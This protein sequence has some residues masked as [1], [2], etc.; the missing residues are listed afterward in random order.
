MLCTSCCFP[1]LLA[2]K[3]CKGMKKVKLP[4]KKRKIEKLQ[5]LWLS[6]VHPSLY[7]QKTCPEEKIAASLSLPYPASVPCVP[8]Y[9]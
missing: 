4:V 5:S 8:S 7:L 9:C 3:R 6:S 2:P 1:A